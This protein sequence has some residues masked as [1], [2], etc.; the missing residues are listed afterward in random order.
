M[1]LS[2]GDVLAFCP[3]LESS[4]VLGIAKIQSLR[5]HLL[6]VQEAQFDSAAFEFSE[7]LLPV[8]SVDLLLLLP[9]PL[10]GK[11]KSKEVI[12]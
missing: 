11:Q 5:F 12:V 9:C 4:A 3:L 1:L 6:F 7:N 8:Y 10:F 2:H